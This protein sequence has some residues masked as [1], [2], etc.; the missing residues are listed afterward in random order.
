MSTPEK[1][2][3]TE[4]SRA[5]VEWGGTEQYPLYHFYWWNWL[6]P[7]L[8]YLGYAQ[9]WYDGPMSSFGFWWFN[10]GWRLPW[11]SHD[12]QRS[13]WIRCRNWGKAPKRESRRD[14]DPI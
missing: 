13:L 14:A 5:G 8:R 12:G 3:R 10:W 11:T 4:W 2:F 7:Y 9:D 6:P 1:K